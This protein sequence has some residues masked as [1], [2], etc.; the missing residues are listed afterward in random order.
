MSTPSLRSKLEQQLGWIILVILLGGCLFVVR[1]SS[2]D[3]FVKPWIISQGSARPFLL[4]FF[5][6][7]GGV[8]AFGFIGV[9]TG[10]ALL[11][12]GYRLVME[13]ASNRRAPIT[14]GT[15]AQSE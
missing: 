4:I 15:L 13:W 1:V 10:P 6:V 7:I 9:F 8:I 3:N 12:V 5:G 14:P 11:A 2:I